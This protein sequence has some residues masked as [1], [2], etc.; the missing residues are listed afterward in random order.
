M[1]RRGG[2]NKEIMEAWLQEYM[3]PGTVTVIVDD[4]LNYKQ[5]G[6]VKQIGLKRASPNDYFVLQCG[7][8]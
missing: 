6:I 2:A 4:G 8:S 3:K 1:S 7:F 5:S